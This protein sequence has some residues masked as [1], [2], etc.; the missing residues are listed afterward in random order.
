MFWYF[1]SANPMGSFSVEGYFF[2]LPHLTQKVYKNHEVSHKNILN[3]LLYL[4]KLLRYVVVICFCS[5][6]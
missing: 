1:T 5:R 4:S 2:D 3:V 6:P